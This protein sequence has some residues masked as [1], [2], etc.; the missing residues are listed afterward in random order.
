MTVTGHDDAVGERALTASSGV[1][2]T[3]AD[4]ALDPATGLYVPTPPS[5]RLP[6]PS[7]ISRPLRSCSS[8]SSQAFGC[9]ITN[10]GAGFA[11]STINANDLRQSTPREQSS[12]AAQQARKFTT[13]A[14]NVFRGSLPRIGGFQCVWRVCFPTVTANARVFVGVTATD[15]GATDPSSKANTVGFAADTADANFQLLCVSNGGAI[16]KTALSTPTTKASLA[17]GDPNTTFCCVYEFRLWADPNEANIHAW[18]YNWST[19]T[20]IQTVTNVPGTLPDQT[21]G[22]IV[23]ASI[24]DT[25]TVAIGICDFWGYW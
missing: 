11:G 22:L 5:M 4:F 18:A 10:V 23:E 14:N 25:A 8:N 7:L 17:T 3:G 12:G 6:I 2:L 24:Q 13:T 20:E 16:T 15:P 1:K 19:L 9:T 21:T